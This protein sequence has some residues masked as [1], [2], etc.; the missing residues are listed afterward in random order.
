MLCFPMFKPEGHD[1][2]DSRVGFF[3]QVLI[4]GGN[5]DGFCFG[6]WRWL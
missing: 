2:P 6:L 1:V 3:F 4:W 5:S